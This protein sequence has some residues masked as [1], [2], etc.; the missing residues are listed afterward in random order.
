MYR[1]FMN[2]SELVEQIAKEVEL[3]KVQVAK[4]VDA[5]TETIINALKNGDDVRL[6][7]FGSFSVTDRKAREG[8]NPQTGEKIKIPA[9]KVAKFKPGQNFADQ[10]NIPKEAAK[11]ESKK[12]SKK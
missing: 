2:K 12:E 5:F 3:P 9:K 10:V 11:K 4:L 8:K 7:G 6:V 1:N